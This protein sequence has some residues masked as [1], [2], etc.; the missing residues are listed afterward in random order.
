[1]LF[2]DNM[3]Q[4]GYVFFALLLMEMT[5]HN[6]AVL[7]VGKGLFDNIFRFKQ[8]LFSGECTAQ[9]PL[10]TTIEIN[11]CPPRAGLFGK[12][13]CGCPCRDYTVPKCEVNY[14]RQ[15]SNDYYQE[16]RFSQAARNHDVR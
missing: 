9:L 12:G 6:G 5:P 14:V 15:C 4:S 11:S 16:V 13:N 1:M 10:Q 2:Y 8:N 7:G 3:L